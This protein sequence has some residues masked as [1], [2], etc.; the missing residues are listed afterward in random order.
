[1]TQK[2][3]VKLRTYLTAFILILSLWICAGSP[4]YQALQ[5][6]KILIIGKHDENV[7][8]IYY[9]GKYQVAWFDRT[10]IPIKDLRMDE[11]DVVVVDGVT[12]NSRDLPD[13]LSAAI[14]DYVQSGGAL[15]FTGQDQLESYKDNGFL[16]KLLP[17]DTKRQAIKTD[18]EVTMSASRADLIFKDINIFPPKQT[19]S[20]FLGTSG[21]PLYVSMQYG[22]GQVGVL[23]AIRP[24]SANKMYYPSSEWDQMT[25]VFYEVISRLT[26]NRENNNNKTIHAINICATILVI[27]AL[28][29][30]GIVSKKAKAPGLNV[31]RFLAEYTPNRLNKLIDFAL[32]LIFTLIICSGWLKAGFP[33]QYESAFYYGVVEIMRQSISQSHSISTWNSFIWM[34]S[35]V[36]LAVYP[37]LYSELPYIILSF[38]IGSV[39]SYK[40]VSILI[41]SVAG[42]GIYSVT[43]K[44]FKNR[45]SSLISA[46]VYLTS[47]MMLV[48]AYQWGFVEIF[49][50]LAIA[51]W[52]L[53][54]LIKYFERRDIGTIL[55]LGLLV[56][57][58]FLVQQQIALFF[59]SLFFIYS[60]I[61]W[62]YSP[63]NAKSGIAKHF[64]YSALV[65]IGLTATW[66]FPFCKFMDFSPLF[67]GD[68]FSFSSISTLFFSSYSVLQVIFQKSLGSYN[69]IT[70]YAPGMAGLRM[71]LM[72]LPIL[73]TFVCVAF[74]FR[75]KK[76]VALTLSLTLSILIAMGPYAPIKIYS[77]L[78]EKI[79]FIFSYIRT[80][81]RALIITN[82]V[83]SILGGGGLAFLLS[84]IKIK[85]VNLFYSAVLVAFAG[86]LIFNVR[87]ESSLY[88]G[89]KFD[90]YQ[91]DLEMEAYFRIIGRDT[92]N[93]E[94]RTLVAPLFDVVSFAA[95]SFKNTQGESYD[96]LHW[97]TIGLAKIVSANFNKV[98]L[99]IGITALH[100]GLNNSAK[101]V[102]SINESL[103]CF[104]DGPDHKNCKKIA[105]LREKVDRSWNLKYFLVLKNA[106]EKELVDELKQDHDLKILEESSNYLLFENLRIVD[107]KIL[108][109]PGV[110]EDLSAA[111][112]KRLNSQIEYTYEETS[113]NR[114]RI[115]IK[116]AGD[117]PVTIAISESF[118]P[119]WRL[120]STSG[121]NIGRHMAFNGLYNGF[122]AD[123]QIPDELVLEY[124]Q[125]SAF[126]VGLATTLATILIILIIAGKQSRERCK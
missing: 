77:Y 65:V 31:K 100:A 17:V 76:V 68:D 102:T 89:P 90:T 124:K 63:K 10:D 86:L 83:T 49:I 88:T 54:L 82:F 57:F 70:N 32:I 30:L 94:H 27:L 53:F 39:W 97:S 104:A 41:F 71:I 73:G 62:I 117:G 69:P 56:G 115:H 113:P 122:I 107:R 15:L 46:M 6:K 45:I 66:W 110:H 28:L 93:E 21:S 108:I 40:I 121:E 81:G 72:L 95:P 20:T 91:N 14:R 47:S 13:T 58:T 74:N 5:Q 87:A 4:Y 80:P 79:P 3:F 123:N 64:F 7:Y 61:A 92:K 55:L 84:F 75:N 109:V 105:L 101:Y 98:N 22:S 37:W 125:D 11:F 52:I 118:F 12:N 25:S 116:N 24:E 26:H 103:N 18:I 59:C 44:I 23:A 112:A 111:D 114:F 119:G 78:S 43:E 19:A 38:F 50:V 67:A 51:P 96:G 99:P 33:K 35:P 34:G 29:I 106:V 16:E 120:R 8:P 2:G 1:M 60:F 126:S 9:S 48:E 42:I 85:K 36:N